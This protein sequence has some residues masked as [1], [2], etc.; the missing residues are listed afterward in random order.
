MYQLK[1]GRPE[2]ASGDD[3]RQSVLFKLDIKLD[4]VIDPMLYEIRE[5]DIRFFT[6]G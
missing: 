6:G 2:A 5:D 4:H 3:A 1:S